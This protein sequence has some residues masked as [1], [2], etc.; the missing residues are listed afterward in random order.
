MQRNQ[1]QVFTAPEANYMRTTQASRQRNQALH[2]NNA[3]RQAVLTEWNFSG[4]V[5]R[6]GP[7]GLITKRKQS[8]VAQNKHPRRLSSTFREN[9]ENGEATSML[10]KSVARRRNIKALQKAARKESKLIPEVE[11]LGLLTRHNSARRIEIP[12]QHNAAFTAPQRDSTQQRRRGVLGRKRSFNELKKT[13]T[14][15]VNG[16]ESSR[17]AEEVKESLIDFEQSNLKLSASKRAKIDHKQDGILTKL[18]ESPLGL[19]RRMW[20]NISAPNEAQGAKPF[21]KSPQMATERTSLPRQSKS[22]RSAETQ[23]SSTDRKSNDSAPEQTSNVSTQQFQANVSVKKRRTISER[24]R[25]PPLRKIW[26]TSTISLERQPSGIPVDFDLYDE[27]DLP[28]LDRSSEAG[29]MV[30]A[31]IIHQPLDDDVM[32]DDEMI[33]CA[34]KLLA[35]EVEKAIK[36]FSSGFDRSFVRNTKL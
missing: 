16:Q 30:S 6:A 14:M 20:T 25:S 33:S 26:P 15:P 17:S 5:G 35:R 7:I 24:V 3:S 13:Y 31:N 21:D 22:L 10:Q 12:S 4:N 36:Q 19:I 1:T 34:N 27:V 2:A 32:T 29:R 28:F 23:A 18:F 8:V 9:K 11:R